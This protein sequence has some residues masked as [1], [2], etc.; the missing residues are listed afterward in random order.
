MGGVGF[1][2]NYDFSV[3]TVLATILDTK[4][5]SFLYQHWNTLK[6]ALKSF[7]FVS[8]LIVS[9]LSMNSGHGGQNIG[10]AFQQK[11]TFSNCPRPSVYSVCFNSQGLAR[12]YKHT[13][14]SCFN[15]GKKNHV[16]VKP[17]L[18]LLSSDTQT[19]CICSWTCRA[20]STYI[21]SFLE[22]WLSHHVSQHPD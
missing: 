3:S 7:N 10:N 1:T 8:S 19:F 6:Q 11:K 9:M 22:E 16:R 21:E 20:T 14:S 15:P 4:N 12:I 18:S 13:R 17:Q 5:L 2:W